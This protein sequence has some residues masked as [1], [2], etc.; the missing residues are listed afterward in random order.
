MK[1]FIAK[2]LRDMDSLLKSCQRLSNVTI[3][4]HDGLISTHKII[5]ASVSSFTKE[6]LEDIPS[7]DQVTVLMPDFGSGPIEDFLSSWM[8]Q[9]D[10]DNEIDRA[11]RNT[12]KKEQD[13]KENSSIVD[14]KEN[15]SVEEP[16]GKDNLS[17]EEL[18]GKE[19]PSVEELAGRENPSVELL[20]QTE[21]IN[22]CE[23]E[24]EHFDAESFLKD[25]L[26]STKNRTSNAKKR[27]REF[28]VSLIPLI[29]AKIQSLQHDLI[30]LPLNDKDVKYN[31]RKVKSIALQKA[32]KEIVLT[33]CSNRKAAKKFGISENR[34]RV[35]F[36]YP[37][38]DEYMGGVGRRG[39][40]SMLTQEEEKIIVKKALAVSDDGLYMNCPLLK[41]VM[42][43]E[44]D[45]LNKNQPGRN[46]PH[47][48]KHVVWRFGH[49][50]RLFEKSNE[51]K[52][53]EKHV[54]C[55]VCFHKFKNTKSVS[56]HKKATHFAFLNTHL[57]SVRTKKSVDKKLNF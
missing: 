15:P 8:N 54:E 50:H 20:F 5:L 13:A 4:C 11:F 3:R 30:L 55:D 25:K 39:K 53:L 21:E 47:F 42:D 41:T 14:G 51:R 56:D 57:Y 19:N 23:T 43:E 31:T 1:Y 17:V 18:D 46:I 44:I 52:A 6:I 24:P 16:D 27:K 38:K 22:V 40:V 7:G 9:K 34:I 26:K 48:P 29:D 45:I 32:F 28:D 33:G 35:L 12:F 36:K 2:I 10:F 49:R 37:E